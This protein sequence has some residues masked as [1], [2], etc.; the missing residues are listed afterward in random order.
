MTDLTA[1]PARRA[2]SPKGRP[3]VLPKVSDVDLTGGFRL[4]LKTLSLILLLVGS[5][6]TQ[7]NK[8]DSLSA[9]LDL[10]EQAR[11]QI[12]KARAETEDAKIEVAK[13][14]QRGFEASLA[15]MK[16]QLKITAGDVGE[17]K[18]LAASGKGR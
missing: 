11:I 4:D 10:Q 1:R 18:V 7:T 5:W 2:A 9:R 16:Q 12:E 17:L 15:E 6:Y 14:Q 8:I 3:P 13:Q